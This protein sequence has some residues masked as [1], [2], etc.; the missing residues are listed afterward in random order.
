[1]YHVH[2]HALNLIA[3]AISASPLP[4]QTYGKM[5]DKSPSVAGHATEPFQPCWRHV[6]FSLTSSSS[7]YVTS[8][9]MTSKSEPA[10]RESVRGCELPN[11]STVDV[12][13]SSSPC[14]HLYS[15]YILL[16]LLFPKTPTQAPISH[17]TVCDQ[18]VTNAR[19]NQAKKIRSMQSKK[20]I[21][22]P[23]SQTLPT[24]T[25]PTRPLLTSAPQP[26]PCTPQT[27]APSSPPHPHTTP[28]AKPHRHPPNTQPDTHYPLSPQA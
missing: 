8:P 13:N 17:S 21:S 3:W 19:L 7:H 12:I 25:N 20:K 26:S 22:N 6:D 24:R 14:P 23:T 5:N 27:Q 4:V 28:R 10:C 9:I 1:M 18:R 11:S 2:I 16:D 15:R